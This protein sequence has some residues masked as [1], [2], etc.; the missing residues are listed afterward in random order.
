M[1]IGGPLVDVGVGSPLSPR[2]LLLMSDQEQK[3]WKEFE[4]NSKAMEQARNSNWIARLYLQGPD[5]NHFLENDHVKRKAEKDLFVDMTIYN[6]KSRQDEN[7]PLVSRAIKLLGERAPTAAHIL[8]A[9]DLQNIF[10]A[11]SLIMDTIYKGQLQISRTDSANGQVLHLPR[12]RIALG[13]DVL[14]AQPVGGLVQP[15]PEEFFRWSM[16]F[17]PND[18]ASCRSGEGHH[19]A[20]FAIPLSKLAAEP[21]QQSGRSFL[22]KAIEYTEKLNVPASGE[23]TST[24]FDGVGSVSSSH[25]VKE[26]GACKTASGGLA[27]VA[28][29]SGVSLKEGDGAVDGDSLVRECHQAPSVCSFCSSP[30][31]SLVSGSFLSC[32]RNTDS[33]KR[34]CTGCSMDPSRVPSLAASQ[35]ARDECAT[36]WLKLLDHPEQHE[37]NSSPVTL[38]NHSPSSCTCADTRMVKDQMILSAFRAAAPVGSLPCGTLPRIVSFISE[39]K[40]FI[41][42]CEFSVLT[43]AADALRMYWAASNPISAPS[44]FCWRT[45]AR[46]P[47]PKT[48]DVLATFRLAP[49]SV[50]SD[51]VALSKESGSSSGAASTNSTAQA[52]ESPLPPS[53]SALSGKPL[54]A[55][56]SF[57][58]CDPTL[59]NAFY[60]PEDIPPPL[61]SWNSTGVASFSWICAGLIWSPAVPSV[62]NTYLTECILHAE[63]TLFRQ[64]VKGIFPSLHAT[65]DKLPYTGSLP[66]FPL[67][68]VPKARRH[69]RCDAPG[70]PYI[71]D[72]PK[73]IPLPVNCFTGKNGN[74]RVFDSSFVLLNL[75]LGHR[76]RTQMIREQE[77]QLG[78]TYRPFQ[79]SYSLFQ[80]L[81]ISPAQ[82]SVYLERCKVFASCVK[83]QELPSTCLGSI[84]C[85]AIISAMFIDTKTKKGRSAKGKQVPLVFPSWRSQAPAGGAQPTDEPALPNESQCRG[86]PYNHSRGLTFPTAKAAF[87]IANLASERDMARNALEK[88]RDWLTRQCGTNKSIDELTALQ[89]LLHFV[90]KSFP[91]RILYRKGPRLEPMLT[92]YYHTRLAALKNEPDKHEALSARLPNILKSGADAIPPASAFNEPEGLSVF[93]HRNTL[94]DLGILAMRRILSFELVCYKSN[95]SN[96]IYL[97][98]PDEALVSSAHPTPLATRG[99]FAKV[100]AGDA[101]K[102]SYPSRLLVQHRLFLPVSVPTKHNNCLA[103]GEP[104]EADLQNHKRED[105]QEPADESK[106]KVIKEE[107]KISG[108]GASGCLKPVS[109][110]VLTDVEGVMPNT[111]PADILK[112]D[113]KR[114]P[115]HCTTLRVTTKQ[116]AR[117]GGRPVIS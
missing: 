57:L 85:A 9:G 82:L 74:D 58:P 65:S 111:D 112:Q 43:T 33:E 8:L 79:L 91:H 64:V 97:H 29:L 21:W 59:S 42:S 2:A 76:T 34:I 61:P 46:C 23:Q 19:L 27:S 95:K 83:L 17:E 26:D 56:S 67:L 89:S 44:V 114:T 1:A 52:T 36:R 38:P 66:P 98:D 32:L 106:G 117:H 115:A 93:A 55:C 63:S 71:V 24:E 15:C 69:H 10:A 105:V 88:C 96:R 48:P 80:M 102:P 35:K 99:Q 18:W 31:E 22:Q 70:C 107:I 12:R 90:A 84:V 40:L 7:L 54:P 72:V 81:G 109:L 49:I 86:E 45:V 78:Y 108:T 4:R 100:A 13:H 68:N 50:P 20:I 11:S 5:I 16:V 39:S 30:S 94:L 28:G 37:S 92:C 60:A 87:D 77:A 110:F 103:T 62:L 116:L 73:A 104:D 101:F 25:V 14:G 53:S 47:S 75:C 6:Y 41:A 3:T 113:D 51:P